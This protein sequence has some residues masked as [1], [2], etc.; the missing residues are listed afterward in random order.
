MAHQP[1]LE[2]DDNTC[3]VPRLEPPEPQTPT[4]HMRR[5][6]STCCTRRG[7][8]AN[9]TRVTQNP[10]SRGTRT[11]EDNT[12]T[13]ETREI[14]A[15][16]KHARHL[17]NRV[18]KRYRDR[19]GAEFEKLQAALCIRHDAAQDEHMHAAVLGQKGKTGGS[20]RPINKTKIVDLARERVREL[21]RDWEAV[22]AEREALLR[23]RVIEGW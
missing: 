14:R 8:K 18:G 1:T 4:G 13:C 15:K 10:R 3:D 2:L 6:P 5:M 22:K 21:L 11:Q 19:L 23:A 7:S 17:Q 20:R 12:D 16:T 9:P